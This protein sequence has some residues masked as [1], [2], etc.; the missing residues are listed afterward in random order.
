MTRDNNTVIILEKYFMTALYAN[1]FK[2]IFQ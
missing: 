1:Y 2:S